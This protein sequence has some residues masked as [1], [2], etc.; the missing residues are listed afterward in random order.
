[1]KALLEI[2]KDLPVVVKTIVV[3]LVLLLGGAYYI[4]KASW[5]HEE[6]LIEINNKYSTEKRSLEVAKD[7]L[8]QQLEDC[9]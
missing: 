1:M 6:K 8:E 2:I 3:I 7:N 9:Q 4:L 5:E